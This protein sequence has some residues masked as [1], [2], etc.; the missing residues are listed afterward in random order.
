MQLQVRANNVVSASFAT[1]AGTANAL[2]TSNNYQ[3]NSIGVNIAGSGTS[4]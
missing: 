1:T 2:N 4:R 3:V